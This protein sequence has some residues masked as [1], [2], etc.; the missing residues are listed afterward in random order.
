V[1]YPRVVSTIAFLLALLSS[2]ARLLAGP[3]APKQ[4]DPKL[5][6]ELRWRSIGPFRGGRVLAVTGVR[7]QP[8][9]YY[10]GSVGGGVW[11]TDDA[12]RTWKPIFDSQPVASIGAIAVAPLDANI[13]YVGSG[14]ADMRSSISVG[15]GMYKSTDAGK[16]WK[17][18]GLSDSRQIGRILVD[19]HD[20]NR[21]FVAALGHAY[22]PN[23]ERGGKS[24]DN[25][26]RIVANAPSAVEH[27][28][29]VEWPW[30]R[31]L[32]F[33]RW[34]GPLAGRQGRTAVRRPRT[35]GNCG[36]AR[37]SKADLSHH[38][39]QGGRTVPLG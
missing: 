4:I 10:F 28:S 34:R 1:S 25:F 16:T 31:T 2:G 11:K 13:I 15:N 24:Q 33:Q 26:R 14:E 27:L 3:D 20:A 32:S 22:G 37:Q 12:G 6:Q 35:D 23:Q 5:F 9:T 7:G 30:K 17:Q 29:S 21:V 38:R 39:C 8:D 18:I 19:P 36:C